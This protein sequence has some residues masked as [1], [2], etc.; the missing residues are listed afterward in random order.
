MSET[1]DSG[2]EEAVIGQQNGL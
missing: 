2:P 1:S